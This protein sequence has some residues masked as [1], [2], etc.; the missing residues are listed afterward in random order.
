[1]TGDVGDGNG[2]RLLAEA[3]RRGALEVVGWKDEVTGKG[4]V[5]LPKVVFLGDGA[6]WI[7]ALA[8][9]HFGDRPEILDYYFATE[10]LWT[11]SDAL[12]GEGSDKARAWA[13]RHSERLLTSGADG[14]L[15]ALGAIRPY[16]AEVKET[17]RREKGIS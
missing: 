3:A 13:K 6:P 9:E 16:Q 17:L 10:H 11:L 4:R 7:W 1:L 15:R 12:Y 2:P 8:S 5:I 14:L